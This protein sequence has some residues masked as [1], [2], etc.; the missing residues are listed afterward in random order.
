MSNHPVSISLSP[1]LVKT[2]EFM[3]SLKDGE[4]MRN[5]EIEERK[6]E[7]PL[8]VGMSRIVKLQRQGQTTSTHLTLARAQRELKKCPQPKVRKCEGKGYRPYFLC[9]LMDWPFFHK[10]RKGLYVRCDF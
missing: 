10:L 3:W 7:K 9:L 2:T 5:V 8:F 6:R 4:R 1:C